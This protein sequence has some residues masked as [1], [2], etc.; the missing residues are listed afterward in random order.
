MASPI[1]RSY[2]S[3]RRRQ[4]KSRRGAAALEFAIVLPMLLILVMG[5]LEVGRLLDIQQIL[6]C[7]ARE[8]ARHGAAN[9]PT[10][11]A[12]NIVRRYLKNQGLIAAASTATVTISTNGT[13]TSG[14]PVYQVRVTLP[15]NSIH[16]VGLP[17][18]TSANTQLVAD[19]S[20]PRDQ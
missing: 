5:V 17:Y 19:A 2:S 13:T 20:W 18:V 4:R 8:G 12:E 6:T 1:L 9:S 11:G 10:A 15:A 7:A 14:F 3:R 16:W